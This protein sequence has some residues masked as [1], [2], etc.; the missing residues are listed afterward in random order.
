MSVVLMSI[1]KKIIKK[2][3]NPK[4]KQRNKICELKD[5]EWWQNFNNKKEFSCMAMEW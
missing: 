4:K 5:E 1:Q 2:K 3:K